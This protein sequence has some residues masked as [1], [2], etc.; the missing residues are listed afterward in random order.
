MQGTEKS[1]F[2]LLLLTKQFVQSV[3]RVFGAFGYCKVFHYRDTGT[4]YGF[5][6]HEIKRYSTAPCNFILIW[7]SSW[8]LIEWEKND[9]VESASRL[10]FAGWDLGLSICFMQEEQYYE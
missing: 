7:K 9:T 4:Q 2:S 6:F 10:D 3:H 1:F 8:I 5:F